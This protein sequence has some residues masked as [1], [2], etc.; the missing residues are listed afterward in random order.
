MEGGKDREGQLCAI[1]KAEIRF[2]LMLPVASHIH[3]QLYNYVFS[4]E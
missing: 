2:S 3:R 1:I 4:N